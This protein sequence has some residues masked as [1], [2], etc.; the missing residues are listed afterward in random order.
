MRQELQNW[1]VRYRMGQ[2]T[3]SGLIWIRTESRDEGKFLIIFLNG[4]EFH[5]LLV[6]SQ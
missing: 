5:Q 4:G 6:V 3:F 1:A 2:G